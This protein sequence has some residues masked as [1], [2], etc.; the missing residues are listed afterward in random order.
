MDEPI[1]LSRLIVDT[2]HSEL[3][4]EHG[5]APGIRAGGADLIEAALARPRHRFAY[6]PDADL[7]DLAA[8]YLFGLAKNHGYLDGN[9]R[10]GFA[11]AATFLVVNG[12]RLTATEPEAYDAVIAVVE[13]RIT[14]EESAAWIR[15]HS[16]PVR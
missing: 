16:V 15:A 8:A 5:G 11:A 14:E 7:A 4:G 10:V 3:I 13:D 1:W 6:S 2:I 12:L 9:K